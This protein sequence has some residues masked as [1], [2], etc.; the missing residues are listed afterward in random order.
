MRVGGER[1]EKPI[2]FP[3]GEASAESLCIV[4]WRSWRKDAGL[5]WEMEKVGEGANHVNLNM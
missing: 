4:P 3:L 2:R 1:S 5:E